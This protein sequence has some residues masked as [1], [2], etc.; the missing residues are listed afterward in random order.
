MM[1]WID[2]L[3]FAVALFC[4]LGAIDCIVNRQHGWFLFNSLF[5]GLNLF[6]ALT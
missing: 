3:S 5:A 2:A 1:E 6:F 4:A